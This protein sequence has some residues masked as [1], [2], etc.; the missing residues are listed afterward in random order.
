MAVGVVQALKKQNVNEYL[1]SLPIIAI[2]ST[3]IKIQLKLE[4]NNLIIIV[5]FN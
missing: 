4:F 5:K 3:H 1:N 2:E